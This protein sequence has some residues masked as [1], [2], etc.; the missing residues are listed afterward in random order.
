MD[1]KKTVRII[2]VD[3]S[4]TLRSRLISML[5][6]NPA[7]QIVG[8]GRD[9]SEALALT[10]KHEADLVILDV[11]MPVQ[12]GIEVLTE[13]KNREPSPVVVMLTNFPYK[14]YR[15][16]CLQLGADHFFDKSTEFDKIPELIE[17]LL[18]NQASN[19][20]H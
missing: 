16:K 9:G 5:T 19:G 3:D 18:K 11:R 6:E 17:K 13:I 20:A 15:E 14:E 7:V 10:E 2:V 12:S 4:D 8:E 1:E